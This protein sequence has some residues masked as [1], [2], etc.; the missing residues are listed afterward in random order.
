MTTDFVRVTAPYI[1]IPI[2]SPAMSCG[3]GRHLM[4][5]Q[6]NDE[7]F[8]TMVSN[9]YEGAFLAAFPVSTREG[10]P[11]WTTPEQKVFFAY[12]TASCRGRLYF[13]KGDELPVQGET[14]DNYILRLERFEQSFPL[15]LSKTNTGVVFLK[16]PP[17]SPAQVAL[18]KAVQKSAQTS[19]PKT[20]PSAQQKASAASAPRLPPVKRYIVTPV[21]PSTNVFTISVLEPVPM[22]AP[23]VEE[24]AKGE[25][26][27]NRL[28]SRSDKPDAATQ[29]TGETASA[30]SAPKPPETAAAKPEPAGKTKPANAASTAVTATA[31]SPAGRTPA[32]PAKTGT[33]AETAKDSSS[34]ARYQTPIIVILAF[35]LFVVGLFWENRRKARLREKAMEMAAKAMDHATGTPPPIPAASLNDFSGSIASMSLGSVTQFLNSDKETGTLH[36]RDKNNAPLGTLVFIKGEIIDARSLKKQGIDAL[37]EVLRHKEGFF[38]FQR[39]EP[40]NVEKT[41]TQGTISILLDAHRIMDEEHKPPAP[42]PPTPASSSAAAAKPARTTAPKPVTKL[43]LHGNR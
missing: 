11:A 29:K 7:F 31:A 17:P 22:T 10:R 30:K 15:Y 28:F 38:S 39:E 2:E 1:A 12:R 40:K 14:R 26:F 43:K 33:P 37:Y 36:V 20:T 16:P 21:G 25:G 5:I 35:V 23:G 13:K 6:E 19:V 34:L 3:V 18:V 27:F 9:E 32:P 8:I 4:L 42:T 41:I 24:K